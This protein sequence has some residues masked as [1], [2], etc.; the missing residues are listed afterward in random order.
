ML[1][2][3]PLGAGF[4]TL[5]LF[6]YALIADGLDVR[7]RVRGV[8]EM[9]QKNGRMVSW[10]RQSYYAGLAPSQG[11]R[12]PANAAVYPIYASPE[13]RPRHQRLCGTKTSQT[14]RARSRTET[15]TWRPATLARV[16]WRSTWWCLP[17]RCRVD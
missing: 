7:V 8:V 14:S 5:A 4:V 3:V 16:R 13:E 11:L 10:S 1:V 15:N 17:V 2:T 9:D 6:L 12:F